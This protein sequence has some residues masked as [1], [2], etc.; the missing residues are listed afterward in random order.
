MDIWHY[1]HGDGRLLGQGRADPD[2]MV[3]GNWLV[4]AW[5]TTI[6]PPPIGVGKCAHFDGAAWRVAVVSNGERQ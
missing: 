4:P 6:A 3:P 1:D 2:P 5:A